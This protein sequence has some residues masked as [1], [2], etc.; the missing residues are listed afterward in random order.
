MAI[1]HEKQK[2]QAVSYA[3]LTVSQAAILAFKCVDS[4]GN[5]YPKK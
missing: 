1:T 3:V 4:K 5:S 2:T